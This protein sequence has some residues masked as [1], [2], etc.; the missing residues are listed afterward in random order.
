MPAPALAITAVQYQ[1]FAR[2]W[3]FA[4]LIHILQDLREVF[5]TDVAL[6]FASFLVLWRPAR[7]DFMLAMAGLQLA[8]ATHHLPFISNHWVL[9]AFVNLSLLLG[10]WL[11][12]GKEPHYGLSSAIPAIRWQL[13]V[14]Y[15]YVVLHKLNADFLVAT[16]SCAG[17]FYREQAQL[18]P[19]LPQ[20]VAIETASIW[21]TLG[22]EAIIPVMLFVPRL[23]VPGAA[24]AAF[25]H[26]LVAAN[27]HSHY[28]NFT[29]VLFALFFLFVPAAFEHTWRAKFS[30]ITGLVSSDHPYGTRNQ[31]IAAAAFIGAAGLGALYSN[32]E[33]FSVESWGVSAVVQVATYF[34]YTGV[35]WAWVIFGTLML[36]IFVLALG[37]ES[38]TDT[39]HL[40]L[41][42]LVYLLPVALIFLNGASPYLGLKSETS[43]A[44]YS[45]LRT[46]GLSNHLF[47]PRSLQVAPYMR[48]VVRIEASDHPILKTYVGSN[49]GLV[50]LMFAEIAQEPLARTVYREE[51]QLHVIEDREDIPARYPWV[52]RKFLGFRP[53][54]LGPVRCLH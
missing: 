53:V 52:A 22:V 6:V 39:P 42:P 40:P 3:A 9:T 13:A 10:L 18:V 25:F 21:L 24:L 50:P 47:M 36:G 32:P 30:G 2:I 1:I 41:G 5:W 45:N 28:Y 51:G 35:L 17:V 37:D 38:R 26:Y 31:L 44:M 27:P 15:F 23:R 46:E 20:S 33:L 54:D 29:A 34:C 49:Y 11:E 8:N 14:L 43:F 7:L 12:R 48:S 4:H 16:T 19:L